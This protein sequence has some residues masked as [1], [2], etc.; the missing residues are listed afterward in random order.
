MIRAAVVADLMG[1]HLRQI[2]ARLSHLSYSILRQVRH[3]EATPDF[4]GLT[5]A[6][7]FVALAKLLMSI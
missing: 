1:M 4:Y 3:V 2:F 5:F 7:E 6:F